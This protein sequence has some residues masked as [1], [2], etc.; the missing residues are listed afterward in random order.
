MRKRLNEPTPS[1]E[2]VANNRKKKALQKKLLEK[3]L[4]QDEKLDRTNTNNTG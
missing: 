1:K 2:V 3:L 4:L